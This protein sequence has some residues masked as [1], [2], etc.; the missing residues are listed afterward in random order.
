MRTDFQFMKELSTLTHID[1]RERYNRL[2]GLVT[3]IDQYVMGEVLHRERLK[4]VCFNFRSKGCQEE[5]AKWDLKLDND[6]IKFEARLLESEQ[7]LYF[8]V[9]ISLSSKNS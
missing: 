4:I 1:V 7:I 3:D 6:L 2:R 8:D 9:C 5:L